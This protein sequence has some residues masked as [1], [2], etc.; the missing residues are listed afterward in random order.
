MKKN[1]NLSVKRLVLALTFTAISIQTLAF[2]GDESFNATVDQYKSLTVS[3]I[4][5]IK[6]GSAP[7][8]LSQDKK[9]PTVLMIHGLSDSPGS[10]KEVSKVYYKRGYNVITVL[11]RDHGL[12]MP[13]RKEIRSKIT[14]A[15]W[16]SDVDKT[17]KIAFDMS[18]SEKVALVGFSLGG[19][20]ALDAA[21]RY[22][23]KISSL[24]MLA[25]LLKMNHGWAAPSARVL[26]YVMYSTKKGIPET[27]HFYPDIAL[28]QTL[29]A[30]KLTKHLKKNVI[31][32]A[33]RNL[34]EMPKMMYLTD[35]DTTV[36]N[37][38]AL[39]AAKELGMSD[40]EVVMYT[41]KK[42]KF[43]VLHRDLPMSSIN[44]SKEANPFIGKML[45]SLEDF[46][47]SIN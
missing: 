39:E 36:V 10:M 4:D 25:P 16:R 46:L 35:A 33:S 5:K 6:P 7:F 3:R 1:M 2:A 40:D 28:N 20:L 22:D 30:Y 45:Q 9:A 27:D 38:F 11:L 19:A 47:V 18:N 41:N 21:D 14:L 24:V 17:M 12:Q 43:T 44:A 42:D 32:E 37:K 34:L 15:N 29:H 8:I 31:S 26:K 23:G 13:Y